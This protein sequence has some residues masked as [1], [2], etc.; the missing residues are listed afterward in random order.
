M[1]VYQILTYKIRKRF[2]RDPESIY[3][4]VFMV[5]SRICPVLFKTLKKNVRKLTFGSALLGGGQGVGYDV[6]NEDNKPLV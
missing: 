4:A 2:C 1:Y 3:Q 6:T 5:K